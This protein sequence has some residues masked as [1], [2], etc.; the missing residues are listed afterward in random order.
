MF[1]R[2]RTIRKINRALGTELYEWQEK[3]ILGESE[4]IP[5]GRVVGR[6]TAKIIKLCLSSGNPMRVAIQDYP[7]R[8]S[9][10][11]ALYIG[12]DMASWTRAKL[13]M[14]KLFDTYVKLSK[15]RG[16]KLR[17]IVFLDYDGIW[18]Q[19]YLCYQS[20][21]AYC[22]T[23]IRPK[24]YNFRL[25]LCLWLKPKKDCFDCCLTCKYFCHCRSEVDGS[26][27]Y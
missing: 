4:F 19:R 2:K 15:V 13:Y 26:R 6:T 22:S 12:D 20:R 7:D 23:H 8:I 18:I 17:E 5:S 14:S 10:E 21:A 9:P 16:L 1:K 27:N 25:R 3:Y 24:I 11:L